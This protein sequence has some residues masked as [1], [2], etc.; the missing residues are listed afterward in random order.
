MC[1]GQPS[2]VPGGS[3]PAVRDMGA[4]GPDHPPPLWLSAL[5]RIYPPRG[6]WERVVPVGARNWGGGGWRAG[7]R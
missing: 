2:R 1:L 7:R 5:C 6:S 3:I 4:N